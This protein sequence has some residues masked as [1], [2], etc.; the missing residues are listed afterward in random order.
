MMVFVP[1]VFSIHFVLVSHSQPYRSNPSEQTETP[2]KLKKCAGKCKLPTP[3]IRTW[4]AGK[5]PIQP[6]CFARVH[7]CGLAAARHDQPV[8]YESQYAGVR[9]VPKVWN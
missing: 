4:T 7:V 8:M 1:P 5:S 2:F 9:V 3:K 6:Q